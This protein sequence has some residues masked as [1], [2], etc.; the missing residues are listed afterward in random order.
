VEVGCPRHPEASTIGSE[1]LDRD[2]SCGW[3]ILATQPEAPM[4]KGGREKAGTCHTD[5]T[6]EREGRDNNL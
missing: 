3:Q 1:L 5:K 2:H 4:R 6:V